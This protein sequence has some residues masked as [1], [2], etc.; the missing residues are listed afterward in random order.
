[1]LKY[2]PQNVAGAEDTQSETGKLKRLYAQA[3]QLY[4]HI[5]VNTKLGQASFGLFA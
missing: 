4:H 5:L 1:M 2:L 3:G